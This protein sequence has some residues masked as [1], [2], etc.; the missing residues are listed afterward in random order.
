MLVR[1]LRWAPRADLRRGGS[2]HL[3]RHHPLGSAGELQRE[4]AVV[5]KAVEDG[6]PRRSWRPR[7]GSRADRGRPRSSG[8]RRDRREAAP[9]PHGTRPGPAGSP[10][11]CPA[12]PAGP[13]ARGCG[14]RCARR[15]RSRPAA[16]VSSS[17]HS[18]LS[19]SMAGVRVW[20]EAAIPYSIG[21][22]PR[23]EIR[24]AVDDSA[25]IRPGKIR[26][27]SDAARVEPL[28][29]EAAVD[30]LVVHARGGAGASGGR[31]VVRQ[32]REVAPAVEHLDR[33]ALREVGR[34]RRDC[35]GRSRGGR[36]QSR[37]WPFLVRRD[38]GEERPLTAHAA[39]ASDRSSQ[40]SCLSS[41]PAETRIEAVV[42]CPAARG[43]PWAPRRG[44]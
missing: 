9:R 17:T 7:G 8:P 42:R 31:R 22:Q 3:D 14:R 2:A 4:A 34:L 20:T 23:Q 21:D 5:G 32:R 43:S 10:R 16:P 38:F 39:S 26:S 19:A 41:M 25:R 12:P 24:F 28:R 11:A 33:T 1:P 13:P 29:P 35:R 6:C 36:T 40:R 15:W 18:P 27:R 37:S 44:S 30:G